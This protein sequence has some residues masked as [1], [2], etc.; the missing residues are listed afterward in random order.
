MIRKIEERDREVFLRLSQEFYSSEAVLHPVPVKHHLDAFGELMRSEEYALGFLFEREGEA[1]GY[2][3][4]AVTYSR[5]AGGKVLWIEEVYVNGACRGAGIGGEFFRFIEGYARERG[6]AR[7][8]LETEPSNVRARA[9]YA[10]HGFCPLE[11]VQMVLELDG[12][13]GE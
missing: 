11:Y 12:E 9:L 5:E 1:V 6:F 4:C 3:L 10:R 8:R 2:A 13:K 7:L